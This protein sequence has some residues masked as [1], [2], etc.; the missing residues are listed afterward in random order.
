MTPQGLNELR[1]LATEVDK[2]HEKAERLSVRIRRFYEW[3]E[4]VLDRN[5]HI[6]L[7][8]ASAAVQDAV[9]CLKDALLELQ[10][11]YKAEQEL[12]DTYEGLLK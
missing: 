8:Y 4:D 9:P 6:G 2:L 12:M 7:S 5:A 11:A 3:E 10:K 1:K